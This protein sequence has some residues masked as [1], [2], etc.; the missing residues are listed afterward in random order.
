L[1]PLPIVRFPPNVELYVVPDR[2]KLYPPTVSVQVVPELGGVAYEAI[3]L[4]VGKAKYV[5][6]KVNL[7]NP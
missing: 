3:K 1:V 4:V 5:G 2:V 7:E 6:A